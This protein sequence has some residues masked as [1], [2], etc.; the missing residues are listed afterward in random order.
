M[1]YTEEQ[2]S[3]LSKSEIIDL[4]NKITDERNYYRDKCEKIINN[5]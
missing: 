3:K 2:I 5:I 4:I 1:F